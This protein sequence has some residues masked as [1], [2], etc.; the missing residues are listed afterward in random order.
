MP[1]PAEAVPLAPGEGYGEGD[2]ACPCAYDL[3][4]P[5]FSP[6]E[7]ERSASTQITAQSSNWH[8][9]VG[10]VLSLACGSDIFGPFN[11]LQPKVADETI[12]CRPRDRNHELSA[13]RGAGDLSMGV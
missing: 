7:R 6:W 10:G 1:S 9:Q 12:A 3:F 11:R 2:R 4:T 13:F 8:P 5:A